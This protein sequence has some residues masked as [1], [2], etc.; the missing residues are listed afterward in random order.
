[1]K[2]FAFSL[3]CFFSH[4][5]CAF[6]EL[7]NQEITHRIFTPFSQIHSIEYGTKK[8][9][10][11]T[12]FY[13]R[14]ILK[15]L[16]SGCF[17]Y[18][19][20]IETQTGKLHTKIAYNGVDYFCYIPA[21]DQIHIT[22]Q[23]YNLTFP[24]ANPMIFLGFLLTEGRNIVTL[25]E[26]HSQAFQQNVES[27]ITDLRSE[28]QDGQR[29]IKFKIRDGWD[30]KLKEKA[31]YEVTLL[32]SKNFFPISWTSF[33]ANGKEL[34]KYETVKF[35]TIPISPDDTT[36]PFYYPAEY[37]LDE[38]KFTGSL[39]VDL[40]KLNE[41]IDKM[42]LP[43]GVTREEVL[44]KALESGNQFLQHPKMTVVLETEPIKINH[45]NEEDLFIDPQIARSI[46]DL[47]HNVL[48]PT[49]TE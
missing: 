23:P 21:L 48:I 25:Q 9:N 18:E 42:T 27:R 30:P 1:M 3:L 2:F 22:K 28:E 31:F 32:P 39:S 35:A 8:E 17:F 44:A 47:D 19:E 38:F 33:D 12:E 40:K 11:A 13:E 36:P 16:S 15:E 20:K 34:K 37:K 26:L 45:L 24:L 7:T 14:F 5:L 46:H 10:P 41:E 49:P 43:K 6:S 29:I 4:C